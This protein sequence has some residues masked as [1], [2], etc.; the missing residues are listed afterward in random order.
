M[1]ST[2]S[3]LT[4][5]ELLKTEGVEERLVNGLWECAILRKSELLTDG[6]VAQ[7]S[8]ITDNIY[9]LSSHADTR[10]KRLLDNNG[11]TLGKKN[12]FS[13]HAAFESN[14]L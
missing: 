9:T 1:T 2:F 7:L 12:F 10:L 5:L 8:E 13:C 11:I 3:A 14:C 6:F 4:I